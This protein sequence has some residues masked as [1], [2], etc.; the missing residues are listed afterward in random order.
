MKTWWNQPRKSQ[1]P[2]G[3]DLCCHG[4]FHTLAAGDDAVGRIHSGAHPRRRG[5]GLYQKTEIQPTKNWAPTT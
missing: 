4:G 5:S 1:A 2:H 3:G